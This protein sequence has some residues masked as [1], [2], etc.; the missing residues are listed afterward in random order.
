MCESTNDTPGTMLEVSKCGA[1]SGIYA[2]AVW[3]AS[4]EDDDSTST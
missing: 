2:R 3:Y 4:F 1:D